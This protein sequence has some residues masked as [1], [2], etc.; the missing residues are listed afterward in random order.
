MQYTKFHVQGQNHSFWKLLLKAYHLHAFHIP[1]IMAIQQN[2]KWIKYNVLRL[3]I[4]AIKDP[5]P[6][7]LH[8]A[9]SRQLNSCLVPAL[10]M[11]IPHQ[12]RQSIA[13]AKFLYPIKKIDRKLLIEIISIIYQ[14]KQMSKSMVLILFSI[15]KQTWIGHTRHN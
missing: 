5:H 9:S 15:A 11:M 1:T 4:Y 12:G 6:A 3:T 7:K 10:S 14:L 13:L 8:A 2:L